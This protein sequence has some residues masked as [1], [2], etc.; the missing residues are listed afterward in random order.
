MAHRL[1]KI[2]A[3]TAAATALVA[4]G[5]AIGSR[6]DG[7]AVA[8]RSAASQHGWRADHRHAREQ[9]LQTLATK[10]GVTE[11]ALRAALKDL[12]PQ[13]QAARAEHVAELAKALGISEAKVTAALD[14]LRAQRRAGRDARGPGR[15]HG[16]WGPGGRPHRGARIAALA[17]A[18]GLE[19]AD[20]RAAL[21]TLAPT[22]RQEIQ[23]RRDALATALAA[24][25]KLDPD[26][27][28]AALNDFAAQRPFGGW[29]RGRRP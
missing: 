29:H 18:L 25:L 20:V 28:K 7:T 17:R 2:T 8:A 26:K 3:A 1:T 5:Y 14:P 22:R 4:G 23:Q 13:R 11:P 19:K 10:L 9:A 6:G 21:Q 16:P 27:V 15:A 12:R 24:E